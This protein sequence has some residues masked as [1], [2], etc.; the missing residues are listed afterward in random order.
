MVLD[1]PS[2]SPL[3]YYR[4]YHPH[5]KRAR[6][7]RRFR[8]KCGKIAGDMIRLL[9]KALNEPS[10]RAFVLASGDKQTTAL[11]TRLPKDLLVVDQKLFGSGTTLVLS[12]TKRTE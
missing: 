7:A 12:V 3:Q 10:A 5:T 6:L 4:D 2:C 8:A 11:K 9:R 1:A